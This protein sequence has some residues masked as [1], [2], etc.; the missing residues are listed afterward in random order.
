M[1]KS[2]AYEEVNKN[3]PVAKGRLLKRNVVNKITQ[4]EGSSAISWSPFS[5]SRQIYEAQ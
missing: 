3:H 5:C 1:E 4:D 2:F